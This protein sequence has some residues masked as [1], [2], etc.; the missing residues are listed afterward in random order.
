MLVLARIEAEIVIVPTE[1]PINAVQK[2]MHPSAVLF[3]GFEPSDDAP[4]SSLI[5]N[6]QMTVDLPGDDILVYNSGDVSLSA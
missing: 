1:S 3:A 2:A 4:A 5:A 6:L